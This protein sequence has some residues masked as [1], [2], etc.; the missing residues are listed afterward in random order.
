M[1][2]RGSPKM[3]RRRDFRCGRMSPC[4]FAACSRSA[5][6]GIRTRTPSRAADFKSAASALPP[7]RPVQGIARRGMRPALLQAEQADRVGPPNRVALV[8]RKGR[9]VRQRAGHVVD[10]VRPVRPEQHAL[11][12]HDRDQVAQRAEVVRDAVVPDA[13][14]VLGGCAV[15]RRRLGQLDLVALLEP[16]DEI[17]QRP[18]TVGDDE[19]EVRDSDPGSRRRSSG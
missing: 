4:R 8:R 1:A 7:L 5:E 10:L 3:C 19:L 16:P 12:A 13:P 14:E 9:G 6:G 18:A 11:G 15:I 17:R 2:T